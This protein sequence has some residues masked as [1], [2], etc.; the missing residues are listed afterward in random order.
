[1]QCVGV[2]GKIYL[3][4]AWTGGFHR[5]R[6]T[7][8][9]YVFDTVTNTWSTRTAMPEAR[10]R[11]SAAVVVDGTKIWVSH[12]NRG[13]HETET[14]ATSYG[15]IDYYETTTDTW[16]LGNVAGFPDAPN[17]RDHTGGGLVNGKICVTGGRDG[18]AVNWPNVA[19][20][21]CFDPVSKTWSVEASIPVSRGG[22]A[23]GTSCD[24]KYLIVAGGERSISSRV[25]VFDGTR[26]QTFTNGLVDSRH[27]TGLGV[28]CTRNR[29]YI[30]SGAPNNG[31]GQA[32]SLEIYTPA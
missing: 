7:D 24:G 10:R 15:W 27:G 28:D 26:W 18:G 9:M 32:L 30:A 16:T 17:P 31:G 2:A 5:E 20:T 11:G 19:P 8:F 12:G 22:S 4:A 6:N 14:F 25:D 29:I 3:P 23:Y 1:M 13:G 21:D